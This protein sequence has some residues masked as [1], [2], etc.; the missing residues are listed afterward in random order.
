MPMCLEST[1]E[2]PTIRD[3]GVNFGDM[4]AKQNYNTNQFYAV[5]G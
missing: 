1:Q 4:S 5:L 2:I 3:G